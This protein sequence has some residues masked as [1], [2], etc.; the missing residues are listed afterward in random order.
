MLDTLPTNA[1]EL[2]Q[3]ISST[4]NSGSLSIKTTETFLLKSG[5][6]LDMLDQLSVIHVAGTKGKVVFSLINNSLCIYFI[7]VHHIGLHMCPY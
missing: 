3:S 1:S 6:T 2:N 7:F 4:H 5:I